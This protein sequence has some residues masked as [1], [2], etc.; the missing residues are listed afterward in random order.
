[1]LASTF[2]ELGPWL[3]EAAGTLKH[4]R[5]AGT[6]RSLA[7]LAETTD[8]LGLGH[9]SLQRDVSSLSGGEGQR[10][11]L[12]EALDAPMR[13]TCY[14]FDEPTR[15]LHAADASHLA[16]RLQ[17]LVHEETIVLL[18]EHNPVVVAA[19]D[20]VVELGPEGGP[21]GGRIVYQG[22]PT[23]APLLRVRKGDR[24]ARPLPPHRLTLRGVTCRTLQ[25]QEAAFV[26]GG[27]DLRDG[28]LG[29]RQND[30][31]ARRVGPDI[32]SLPRNGRAARPRMPR[33]V[34]D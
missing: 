11:R 20:E 3:R 14:V 19:A 26:L 23:G 30:D 33:R 2:R 9:L 16:V 28:R 4:A 13:A 31:G 6:L 17:E 15:G 8:S 12:V 18:A 5:V 22:S 10:L 24:S 21:Q 7:R 29:L 32:A 34:A 1:M 25:D 27:P